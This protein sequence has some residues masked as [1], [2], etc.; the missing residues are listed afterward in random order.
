[1]AREVRRGRVQQRAGLPDWVR[2]RDVGGTR[3]EI[4][5]ALQGT[6]K[7]AS[8]RAIS[9]P[10]RSMRAESVLRER[11]A[12]SIAVWILTGPGSGARA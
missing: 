1:M 12:R 4:S 8:A 7:A 10:S 5:G 3:S 2:R 9:E 6:E 11:P